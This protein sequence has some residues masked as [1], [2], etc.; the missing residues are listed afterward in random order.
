[1]PFFVLEYNV[2][3]CMPHGTFLLQYQGNILCK[4]SRHAYHAIGPYF[5]E[6]IDVHSF[7][8]VFDGFS[9]DGGNEGLLEGSG[10]ETGE[11][12]SIGS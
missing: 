12:I 11:D 5:Y 10:R 2:N 9:I 4:L 6:I 8:R 1:M 3:K 7:R